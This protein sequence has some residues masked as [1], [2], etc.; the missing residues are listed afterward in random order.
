MERE[1]IVTDGAFAEADASAILKRL[2]LLSSVPAIAG[3]LWRFAPLPGFS[4]LYHSR[5]TRTGHTLVAPLNNNQI[6]QPN[7]D[8]RTY[9]ECLVH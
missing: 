9:K 7:I 2:I 4:L 3:G 8:Y 1:F 5:A 6:F